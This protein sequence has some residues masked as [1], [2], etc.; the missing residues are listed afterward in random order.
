MVLQKGQQ[1]AFF[2]RLV[3]KIFLEDWLM[4]LVALVI[5]LALWF[6]VTGLRTNTKQR[7]QNIPLSIRV[8][9]NIE[10]TNSPVSEVDVIVS[11]DKRK[12]D[13]LNA[14]DLVISLDLTGVAAGE[15][16]VQI[17]PENVLIDLPQ[18]I[19]LEEIQPNKIAVK[20]ETVEERE[21]A[22]RAETEGSL[23]EGFEF[24][25]EPVVQ[26]Q[27]IRVRGPASFIR[28]LDFV[29]TETIDIANRRADFTVKQVPLNVVNPKATLLDTAVDV[30]FRIGEKRIERLF[31]V[32]VETDSGP[33]KATLV[34]FG[35]RSVL[36]SLNSENLPIEVVK[37]D[38]GENTLR[39]NLPPEL[40]G[41]IEIKKLN[42][43]P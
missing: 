15:R 3:R 40:E 30:M 14:R 28:T 31:Q 9:N 36:D 32:P 29:S 17:L 38:A 26:P 39:L 23:T 20:L 19:K 21:V 10:I 33:R 18:G 6:G 7:F 27:K 2:S 1:T 5:T 24:Y 35:A 37:N 42:I 16:T 41:R 25:G 43:N 13:Q 22:V 11:G 4:K 34:L 12:I 8:S